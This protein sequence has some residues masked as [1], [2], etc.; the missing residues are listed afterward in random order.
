[1][2]R[3]IVAGCVGRMGQRI[4]AL[5]FNDARI[6]VGGGFDQ[7][8]SPMVGMDIGDMVGVGKRQIAVA[9]SIDQIVDNGEVIVDFT[10]PASTMG[11]IACALK[12]AKKMVIGT[13][14]F[15]AE[16]KT[17]IAQAAKEIPIV[18]AP[19][20]S[21]GVN[22]LFTL[23]RKVAEILP[24]EYDIEIIEAHHRHKKDAPS[25]TAHELLR[26]AAAGRRVDVATHAV[27]G[28]EGMTGERARGTI[29]VH[30]VRG[31]DVVGD[32]T[33]SFMAEGERVE[34]THRASSRD[35]FAKGALAAA[36]FVSGKTR[37]LFSM[38]DVLGV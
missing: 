18:C 1:M 11:H 26:Q 34:L 24:D 6:T 13:T 31:G 7:A 29:G 27:Y 17:A 35:A 15:S 22:L 37:G 30:A 4:A 33:V 5:G 32:H 3:I 12:H 14:G 9:P 16:E 38:Q 28:R 8:S 19:N 20:M 21:I 25:G 10:S 36:V 23:V 2:V